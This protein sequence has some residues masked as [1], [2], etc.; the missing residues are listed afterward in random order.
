[1]IALA[2]WETAHL[3]GP[4]L[5]AALLA[6]FLGGILVTYVPLRGSARALYALV[7]PKQDDEE[8]APAQRE[9]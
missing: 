4:V 9:D 5:L 7:R 3:N 8:A 6:C 2:F 1:M